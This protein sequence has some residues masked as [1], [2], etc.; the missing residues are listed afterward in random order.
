MKV[1][2][3]PC[4]NARLDRDARFHRISVKQNAGRIG[5]GVGAVVVG[6][7]GSGA[8]I[9][10]QQTV[11]LHRRAGPLREAALLRIGALA[12]DAAAAGAKA[13]SKE[14]NIVCESA[15]GKKNICYARTTKS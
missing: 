10:H 7:A 9:V 6:D 4:K 1:P 8:G 14:K 11:A 12:A 2:L 13:I 3:Q 5:Q 15:G